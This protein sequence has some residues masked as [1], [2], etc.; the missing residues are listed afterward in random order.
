[1]SYT[2]TDR[3]NG[4]RQLLT[5]VRKLRGS[6]I[7]VGVNEEPHADSGLTNAELGAIHEFG[8]G[9]VPER[10]FLRAWVDQNQTGW[11][12]WLKEHIYRALLG[13]EAWEE[14]F[15]KY[16]VDG[17]RARMRLGIMP[18]LAPATIARKEN[19]NTPLIETE[20]LINAIEYEVVR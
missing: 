12:R 6:T 18:P 7:R 16:A 15:G 2:I 3:D 10:S 5:N 1:M 11:M 17:I 8:L 13:R 9:K 14:N 20:Q 19:G 4:Y